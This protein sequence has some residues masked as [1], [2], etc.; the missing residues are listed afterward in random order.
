MWDFPSPPPQAHPEYSLGAAPTPAPP[1]SVPLRAPGGAPA[2]A[3]AP[4]GGALPGLPAPPASTSAPPRAPAPVPAPASSSSTSPALATIAHLHLDPGGIRRSRR[5]RR[6]P[7]TPPPAVVVEDVEDGGVRG[8]RATFRRPLLPSTVA[9]Q[10]GSSLPLVL[11]D[12]DG[13]GRIVKIK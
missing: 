9:E 10:E 11:C 7:G 5:T 6:C 4:V 12:D 8:M 13:A 1:P 2:P 3:H